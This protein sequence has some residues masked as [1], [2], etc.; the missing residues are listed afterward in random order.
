[1]RSAFGQYGVLTRSSTSDGA[2]RVI[3]AR[4]KGTSVRSAL[5]L[6]YKEP[7]VQAPASESAHVEQP[8]EPAQE[9]AAVGVVNMTNTSSIAAAS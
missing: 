1:M 3:S 5:L 2:P 4:L 8:T 9:G 7:S 6:L